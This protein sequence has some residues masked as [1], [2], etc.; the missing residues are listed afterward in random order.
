M[1]LIADIGSG[2]K[3]FYL[4]VL[5]ILIG[6]NLVALG[7]IHSPLTLEV[8]VFYALFTGLMASGLLI[9]HSG[10]SG[11]NRHFLILSAF[12]LTVAGLRTF[13]GMAG[14]G[15]PKNT[16]Q[17]GPFTVNQVWLFGVHLH[18]Y[19]LGFVLLLTAEIN[20]ILTGKP[21]LKP[22]YQGIGLGLIADELGILLTGATYYNS[23]SYTAIIALEALLLL[24]FARNMDFSLYRK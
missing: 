4:K 3:R 5:L 15:F 23:V 11:M 17:I 7:Y 2:E 14:I 8:K 13:V 16:G 9:Y 24:R 20:H 18:H 21:Q 22:F 12:F 6:V 1:S 19:Y 10:D